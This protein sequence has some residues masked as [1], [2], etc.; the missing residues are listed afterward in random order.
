[1]KNQRTLAQRSITR[2][3]KKESPSIIDLARIH[4]GY[5]CKLKLVAK[6]DMIKRGVLVHYL[7]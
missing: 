1:M 7:N 5:D 6:H 2:T 4:T 3:E